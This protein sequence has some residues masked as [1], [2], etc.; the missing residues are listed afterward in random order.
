MKMERLAPGDIVPEGWFRRQLVLQAQGLHG[1]LDKVWPDVRD[2]K[3]FGGDRDGWER[4]P[5][6]LDGFVPL[7]YLLGDG[8]LKTRAERY[9]G[10]ILD[11]QAEDGCFYPKNTEK[12]NGDIW[13]IFLILK[14]LTEYADCSGESARIEEAVRRALL[15]LDGYIC[16]KPPFD[17]AA[18]RWYECLVS[19]LW[20][21]RRRREE[22]LVRFAKRLKI[23]GYDFGGAVALWD[24]P[25]DEWS[26]ETHVVNIAMALKSEALYCELTGEKAEGLAERM[27]DRLFQSHGTAYC[28][29]T[30][31]ECLSGTS[32]SQGSELC[33]IVEAMYSYEWLLRLTGEAKWGD[34][35]ESLAFNALP[36]A[37]TADMWGHQYDQQVNQIACKRFARQIFRSNGAEANLFGLE[38]NFGCCTANFGQGWPKF[39]WTAFL[40]KGNLPVVCSPLP[41]TVR[42]GDMTLHC[43]SEYP[44]RDR[45]SLTATKD[46]EALVRVPA[47]TEPV[48]S[49]SYSMEE[50]YLR[51]RLHA[52]EAAYITFPRRVRLESRPGE[53][54]C[55]KCGPLLFAYPVAYREE[56]YEY[57]RDGVERKD[58]YC[59]RAY[60]TDGE[61]R[62]ALAT[63]NA[64]AFTVEEHP[65]PEMPFDRLAPAVTIA[66]KLAPVEWE[67]EEGYDCV[68]AARAGTKRRGADVAA[69][70]FP[71]GATY[72]KIAEMACLFDETDRSA[73]G[74]A[75]K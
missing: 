69:K 7:A 6:F 28:H 68:A 1:N 65:I 63:A 19:V 16:Q 49:A 36:A 27:L 41:A 5:Y 58:P 24:A 3:W 71:Y 66:T 74:R 37:V 8:E 30:G 42:Y 2:S 72:L 67:Y 45:F 50:G 39:L 32:P 47:W 4:V 23:L 64:D 40:R 31:D 75:K 54:W 73:Q 38:P 26:F 55:V 11:C 15:F 13:S 33:G 20:L 21:Y 35:L 48:C 46:C 70:L 10:L 17:W 56:K 61:W 60:L 44:F 34:L 9:I 62:Y 57:V 14:V 59:D 12:K 51:V 52:G 18:A 25:R 43:G 22:W 53:R 29:F